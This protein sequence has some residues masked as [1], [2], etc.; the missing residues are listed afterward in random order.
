MNN[1]GFIALMT[2]TIFG[3]LAAIFVISS[4][5]RAYVQ[6]RN[7]SEFQT[8][9]VLKF[10]ALSCVS[11]ARLKISLAEDSIENTYAVYSGNCT[12]E[13]VTRDSQF[14]YV[15][16]SAEKEGMKVSFT[17]TIDRHTLTVLEIE[18]SN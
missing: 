6:A 17:S 10:N 2:V 3:F 5:G 11:I 12:I 1:R 16:T 7:V 4:A 8:L 18:K 14:I 15:E 9:E 13:R